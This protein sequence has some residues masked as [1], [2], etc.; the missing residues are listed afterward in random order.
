MQY[1]YMQ[2]NQGTVSTKVLEKRLAAMTRK[3]TTLLVV[4]EAVNKCRDD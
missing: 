2:T 4:I 1:Q 3:V